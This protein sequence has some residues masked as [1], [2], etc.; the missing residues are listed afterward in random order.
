M[1]TDEHKS[2]R[3]RILALRI[4]PCIALIL[5]LAFVPS[6]RTVRDGDAGASTV[7][8]YLPLYFEANGQTTSGPFLGYW[9]SNPHIGE[10]VSQ[11]VMFN[12]NW[13][14]WF[15]FARLELYDV[16]FDV[17]TGADIVE[18]Q[19]GQTFSDSVGYAQQIE[20]F[21]P[22]A[23][24]AERFF[25]D[26]GHSLTTGFRSA[27]ETSGVPEQLG[28][29]ISDEFSIGETV[30]QFFEY[31]AF[32]W[33]SGAGV[34]RVA[35]G[36]LDAGLNGQ[37]AAWQGKPD[38]AIDVSLVQSVAD[39]SGSDD[40]DASYAFSLLA[41]VIDNTAALGEFNITQI[42]DVLPGE[43]WLEVDLGDYSTTAWVGNVPVLRTIVVIGPEQAPTPTGEFSIYLKHEVQT[44]SGMGWD[45]TPYYQ[46]DVPWVAYFYQDYGFH[47]STWRTEFGFG[48][49]Q[50]CVVS[51]NEAAEAIWYFAEYGLRVSV[52]D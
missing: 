25:P 46:A 13:T 37:I 30:Y 47:G 10:P 52:H 44:M 28:P 45:G 23:S 1:P 27:Y 26:T 11:I 51:P 36:L 48:D 21:L 5:A 33:T 40:I 24:G 18:I 29:P 38:G 50:G 6:L 32:S 9:L 39:A 34:V 19:I 49:G 3:V 16:P 20:A 31:G 14:Q 15:E 8:P 41:G 22:K 2:K 42:A 7:S 43:R 17:A 4:A 12:G 35:V